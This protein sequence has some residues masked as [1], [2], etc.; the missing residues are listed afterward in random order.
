MKENKALFTCYSK[1]DGNCQKLLQGKTKLLWL[2]LL[3]VDVLSLSTYIIISLTMKYD[4][5]VV[6]ITC[7]AVIFILSVA[8]FIILANQVKKADKLGV[9]NYYEFYEKTIKAR[10]VKD[11]EIKGTANHFYNE[12]ILVKK[13]KDYVFISP[14]KASFYP[15]YVKEMS[16]EEYKTLVSF[17]DKM[18]NAKRKNI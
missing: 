9:I 10:S 4:L 17:I 18:P 7:S 2:I 5:D 6:I 16:E 13:V 15:I 14:T 11:G 1:V 8:M 12:F 3:I